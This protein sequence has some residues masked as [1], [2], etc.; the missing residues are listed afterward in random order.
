MLAPGDRTQGRRCP[1]VLCRSLLG[2]PSGRCPLES[3]PPAPWVVRKAGDPWGPH[4]P[5]TVSFPPTTACN[6]SYCPAPAA[7]PEGSRQLLA[8]EEGACCPS[9]NCSEYPAQRWQAPS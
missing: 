5:L 4:G 6:T 1:T 3:P 9:Q 7:C 8:Y 2:D